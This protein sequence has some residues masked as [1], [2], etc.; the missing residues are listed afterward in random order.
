MRTPI[1]KAGKF[2]QIKQ[3]PLL[4]TEKISEL[5]NELVRLKNAVPKQAEE[6]SRLA[7]LGDFS[8]NAGYQFAKG[9]LRGMNQRI[10]ELEKQ[11]N[12]AE[13]IKPMKDFSKIMVGHTVTLLTNDKEIV[14]KILGSEES[15][16]HN[17]VISHSS[18]IG[19]ALIG[20]KVGDIV[21]VSLP[22]GEVEYKILKIE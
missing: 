13:E 14:Y 7:D 15:S 11:L 9:K 3:D 17:G 16:P 6:V 5:N 10:F 22:K 21:K 8:E 19:Y 12:H 20:R 4:S 18:P 2:L 1:R